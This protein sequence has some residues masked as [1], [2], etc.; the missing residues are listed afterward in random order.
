MRTLVVHPTADLVEE[1]LRLRLSRGGV[2]ELGVSDLSVRELVTGA[3]DAANPSGTRLSQMGERLLID[4]IAERAG[5]SLQ[6]IASTAGL[7]RGLR[8]IFSSL[9]R[10]GIGA[11]K[12]SRVVRGARAF[13]NAVEVAR[14]YSDY[15]QQLAT[16]KLY[17][18]ADEWDLACRALADGTAP[19]V[20]VEAIE[21]RAFVDWDGAHIRLLDA[22]LQRGLRVVVKLPTAPEGRSWPA[23]TR[24]LGPT[25]SMLEARHEQKLEV[26][27]EPL[28]EA[29]TVRSFSCANTPFLEAREV[30]RQVRDLTDAGVPLERI[31]VCAASSARRARLADALER[32]GVA[33][34][35]RS[36]KSVAASGTG[37]H[38]PPVRAV[39][40][41][42]ALIESNVPRDR[43]IALISSRYVQGGL[44]LESGYLSPA[45]VARVLR[46]AGITEMRGFAERL[47]AW[48]RGQ[49]EQK[50][51]E[52]DALGQHITG[53]FA[54]LDGLPAS[55]TVRGH[56]RALMNALDRLEIVE[57]ARGFRAEKIPSLNE[58]RKLARDQS[59]VR[60]LEAVLEELPRVADRVGLG[61]AALVRARFAAL[62]SELLGAVHSLQRDVRGAAVELSAPSAL[63]GR[64]LSHLFIC[65]LTDGEIPAH[66][67]EDPI[68][69]DDERFELNRALGVEALPLSV[70]A[71]ER[72]PLVF[73]SLVGSAEAVHLSWS[74]GDE[75]GAP[76][77]R[78]PFIDDLHPAAKEI[79]LIARDP[80]VQIASARTIDELCARSTL[81][82]LGDRSTLPLE[83][84]SVSA[85]LLRLIGKREPARV[86]RL[87][88]ILEVERNR[89]QFFAAESASAIPSI[90]TGALLSPSL[91]AELVARKIPGRE[92][93]PLSASSLETYSACPFKFFMRSVLGVGVVEEL[94]EEL[95]PMLRGRLHH[96]VLERWFARLSAEGK[97]PLRGAEIERIVLHQV[98]D[99]VIEEW[100]AEKPVG[101]PAL[102]AV[103]DRRLRRLLENLHK[104]EVESPPQPGS[105]PSRF[106]HRFGP[107]PVVDQRA[108]QTI[109][110]HGS[111]DRVDVGDGQALVLDYKAGGRESYRAA[112]KE[113]ALCVTSWQLPLYAAAAK[114]ELGGRVEARFY[115]LKDSALTKPI[116]ADDRFSFDSVS[117]AG[118]AAALS[119]KYRAMCAGDFAVR[120][121]PDACQ[122]CDFESA[123]RVVRRPAED[124]KDSGS[125][126]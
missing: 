56:A 17:D 67:I 83:E 125:S 105:V 44:K 89:D 64:S 95:D 21:L 110:V 24:A 88:A 92:E 33:V 41:L 1:E 66:P 42:Y 13:R 75:D 106:E 124:G 53:I 45:K 6:T 14:L 39:L 117:E 101:H 47:E 46:E 120:P 38:A 26:I 35:D 69:S 62:L 113:E 79:A 70:R 49:R 59:A 31:A 22:F 90:Y 8:R 119:E 23:I 58:T 2:V 91:R 20:D 100:K 73:R 109:Y 25:L 71:S 27:L 29:P 74:R 76:I 43:L 77:I 12:F 116:S 10:A 51:A 32:Y 15:Q 28:H 16:R 102:F 99:A 97:L 84:R 85:D 65:G 40:E 48:R 3:C 112:L 4:A 82:C 121:E 9:K 60:D 5:G 37:S 103:F 86:D 118:I 18:G 78:S 126:T 7:R 80:I 72:E 96:Q 55:A 34:S 68:L 122:R 98:C 93:A 104:K 81:E 115:S 94:E 11:E 30:A 63:L 123:C 108:N 52:A 36:G 111:I 50:R 54:L 57:R 87:R 107:L 19:L 61:D 114:R